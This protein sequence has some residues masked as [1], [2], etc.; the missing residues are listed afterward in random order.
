M[1]QSEAPLVVRPY[2]DRM[3]SSEL[4][5]VMVGGFA[6]IAGG[7]F[8]GYVGMGV[9]AG[10]LLTASVIS[11]PAALLIAKVMQPEVEQPETLGLAK[12]DI[13]IESVNA[14]DAAATGAADGA[15]LAINVGAQ[16]IAFLGL[17]A[18]CNLILRSAGA[19]L[20]RVW[21]L[22]GLLGDV[23]APLAWLMGVA[24]SDCRT[25]GSLIGV[26]TIANEFLA[27]QQLTQIPAEA[28]SPR[29]RM[30]ATYAL[31]GF[32]NFGSVGVQIGGLSLL[33]PDRRATI[34]KLGL[35][36]MIGGSLAA[37]MT[38]C[39]AGMLI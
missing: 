18:L 14:L 25:I 37:F 16:M 29:S 6:T 22:E 21:T 27:Y 10:H 12:V 23:C 24:W 8:V 19:P 9:E 26:K 31:C 2:L 13:P 34:A 30:I 11:A 4:M 7:V 17:I 28:I 33:A 38:A 20:G 39:V 36:A 32:A 15:R 5:S 3:T 1:G 35:R